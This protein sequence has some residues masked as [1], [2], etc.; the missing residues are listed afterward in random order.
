[1]I[2]DVLLSLLIAHMM[3]KKVFSIEADSPVKCVEDLSDHHYLSWT[4]ICDY[5]LYE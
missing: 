5:T 2:L 4:V 3:L 1:M